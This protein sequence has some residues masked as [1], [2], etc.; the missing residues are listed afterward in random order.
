MDQKQTPSS[1]SNSCPNHSCV[2]RKGKP[3][4]GMDPAATPSSRPDF[5]HNIS[6]GQDFNVVQYGTRNWFRPPVEKMAVPLPSSCVIL[7]CHRVTVHLVK[8]PPHSP[9]LHK[10][11]LSRLVSEIFTGSVFRWKISQYISWP[12]VMGTCYILG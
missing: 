6:T 2:A 5:S 1:Q 3:I 8:D 10:V 12:S 9:P 7:S 11:D 4:Q